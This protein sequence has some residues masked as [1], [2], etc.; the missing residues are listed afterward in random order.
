VARSDIEVVKAAI[1]AF[2]DE[3]VEK[4]MPFIHPDFE[5][6][7]PPGM[8]AEPDTYRGHEGVRRY[9]ASFY[10]AM[11]KIW[12]EAREFRGVGGKVLFRGTLHSRGRSTGIES[13]IDAFM[14]WTVADELLI[15]MEIFAT[16]DEALA[17][18]EGGQSDPG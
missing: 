10:D 9:F 16:E 8:A 13:G 2:G 14:L 1:D 12:L 17:S 6:A 4:L 5:S 18:A 15:R 3:D 11:D 7:T